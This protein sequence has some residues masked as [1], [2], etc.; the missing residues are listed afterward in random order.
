MLRGFSNFAVVS[1]AII[2]IT[3]I[4]NVWAL[5]DGIDALTE[6]S[7]GRLLLLK[8]ALF[9]GMLGFAAVNR[10]RLIPALAAHDAGVTEQALNRIDRNA[11]AEIAL[12][13]AIFVIVGFLGIMEPSPHEVH[14]H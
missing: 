3:G 12:G 8:I 14:T 6:S 13:V 10:L 9:L 1:V 5:V 4:V 2:L 11:G 7:Y